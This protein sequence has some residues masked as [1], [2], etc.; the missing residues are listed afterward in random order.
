MAITRISDNQIATSTNATV[1]SL[2]FL[3]TESILTLPS[4]PET[5]RPSQPPTGTLRFNTD[6][7]NAE[8]YVT[9]AGGGS[10][11]WTAVAGGGPSLGADSVVRT[12]S[13]VIGENITIGPVANGNDAKYSNGLSSGPITI[14][15]TF[16][17]TVESGSSWSIV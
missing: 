15:N 6:I 1:D 17:V 11:G 13:N 2:N 4:G 14:Q 9:N 5:D 3:D 8:I 10:P 16:T 12:N 7:D